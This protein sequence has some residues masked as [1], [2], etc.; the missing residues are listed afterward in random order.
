MSRQTDRTRELC[1]T[2][3]STLKNA[4]ISSVVVNAFLSLIRS[5]CSLGATASALHADTI[6]LR[7][8]LAASEAARKAL[9]NE[10][11]AMHEANSG[12]IL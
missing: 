9:L 2:Y 11:K 7:E 4:G 12:A 6:A 8:Q 1:Q 10:I 3:L 5:H